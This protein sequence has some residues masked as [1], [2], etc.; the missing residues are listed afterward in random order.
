MQTLT[1]IPSPKYAV[2]EREREREN[3]L[4]GL[5]IPMRKQSPHHTPQPHTNLQDPTPVTEI[6]YLGTIA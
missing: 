6:N 4:K 5:L 3:T 1:I 2:L